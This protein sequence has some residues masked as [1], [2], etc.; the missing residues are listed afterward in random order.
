TRQPPCD[1][2]TTFI[3]RRRLTPVFRQAAKDE[4][5]RRSVD[6]GNSNL[7]RRLNRIQT[8]LAVFPVLDRLNVQRDHRPKRHVKLFQEFGRG[9]TVVHRRP[10]DETESGERYDLTHT[11]SSTFVNKK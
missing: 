9:F 2:S 4:R 5:L 8:Q 7:H 11:R 6:L 1:S 3:E 10:A